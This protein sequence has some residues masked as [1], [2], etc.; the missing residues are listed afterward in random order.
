V[1]GDGA[2]LPQRITQSLAPHG[3][4]LRG[5]FHPATGDGVPPLADGSP[6]STMMLIGNA[7]TGDG[8]PM[9][10]AFAAARGR[11]T[12][13]DPLNDWTR[14][15]VAP[16][17][18]ELGAEPL[19]PFGGPPHLPFQRWAQRAEP[20]APSPLGLLIHPEYGL[21]HAYRAALAFAERLELPAR[22]E[23]VSPCTRCGERPC[24]S[25]CPVGAFSGAGFDAQACAAHLDSPEGSD[26][27]EQGCRARRACPVAPAR[28][29]R[30]GQAAFHMRAFR[31]GIALG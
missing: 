24:L 11:F 12:G 8:D 14:A 23:A 27:L 26:C 7:S 29:H 16:L 25:A 3:L 19:Y 30:P 17:A 18:T 1:S 6:T 13:A 21:W 20:V 5:G 4:I 22:G 31:R 2:G 15:V 28:A 9:W 10:R